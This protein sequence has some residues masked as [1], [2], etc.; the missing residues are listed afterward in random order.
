[1][2]NTNQFF[3]ECRRCGKQIL[4]TQD[5]ATHKWTPCNPEILFFVEKDVPNVYVTPDGEIK[6][7]VPSVNGKGET[8]YIRHRRD[9]TK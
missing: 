9:C 2:G 4:M 6:H 7:G 1:M 3:T 5:I 8:G